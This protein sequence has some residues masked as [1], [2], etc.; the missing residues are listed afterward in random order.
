MT[1]VSVNSVKLVENSTIKLFVFFPIVTKNANQDILKHVGMDPDATE[2]NLVDICT[3]TQLVVNANSSPIFFITVSFASRVFAAAAQSS[4]H[5]WGT[6]M[7]IQTLKIPNAK[8]STNELITLVWS[9]QGL[10]LCTLI[11][12]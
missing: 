10:R 7:R 2:E 4:K 3:R 11:G 12:G 9:T 1:E 5:T 8:I 6:F